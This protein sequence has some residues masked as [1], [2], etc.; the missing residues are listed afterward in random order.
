MKTRLTPIISYDAIVFFNAFDEY[1]A[2]A[3]K[4]PDFLDGYCSGKR[5]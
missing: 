5:E 3:A 2:F 1:K 4:L